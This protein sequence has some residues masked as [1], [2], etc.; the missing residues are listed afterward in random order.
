VRDLIHWPWS[1]LP[2]LTAF[3][4]NQFKLVVKL[5]S[6][7]VNNC[8]WCVRSWLLACLAANLTATPH[9]TLLCG[10]TRLICES[11][12]IRR[13]LYDYKSRT[14]TNTYILDTNA[15]PIPSLGKWW[16]KTPLFL[17]EAQVEYPS[18]E[19][20]IESSMWPN[21]SLNAYPSTHTDS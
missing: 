8:Q 5:F 7:A 12:S 19:R 2:H 20:A 11:F 4:R 21:C 13:Q 1:G 14:H 18:K 10:A 16:G 9:M 17:S 15:R 6:P 3:L